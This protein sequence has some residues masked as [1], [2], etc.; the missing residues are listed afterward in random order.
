MSGTFS[1]SSF[2]K[3]LVA[4]F[5][6]SCTTS[7]PAQSK[8]TYWQQEVRYTM[9]I[10]MDVS[11]N[12]YSG[13]QKIRYKNNS[14]DIL[15]KAFFHLYLNAFQPNSVMD[16]R[17][18]TIPDPDGRIGERILYLSPDEIGY[19]KINK[20]TMNGTPL[21]YEVNGTILE[22]QLAK[23]IRPGQTVT[24]DMEYDAQ[25]PVQI[26]R[27]G[28]DNKEGIRYS[29]SQWY[30]KL[31]EYDRDGWHANPYIGREFYGVWGNFE[32]NLTID[33]DYVVAATG[34]LQNAKEIGHGYA[35]EPKAKKDYL[36][37]K[38]KAERVHDFVWA[39]DPD[40]VHDVHTTRDGITLHAFYQDTHDFVEN[41]KDLLPI[42]DE[43]F[44]FSNQL[45]G[46]YPYPVYSF[47]QGGDGGM[48]YPMATLITGHRS[49]TSLVGVSV[50]ELM[51]SWFQM[52]YGFNESLYYWMDEGFTSY[53]ETRVIDHL[54]K[55]RLIPGEPA[56]NPYEQALKGYKNLVDRGFEEPLS[57]HADHFN[58]NT[59][60]SI[61][62]YTKGEVFLYQLNYV[63]GKEAVERGLIDFFEQWKY[64]HP[65]D[66]DFV[67]VMEKASD[68]ELDWYREYM[69][70]SVKTIDYAIDT[71]MS[72]AS[73]T[74]IELRRI[75]FM[76]M[77]VD[78]AVKLTSG[79]TNFYTI[80]LDLM[81]GSK[82]E[83]G[84][85][86][87]PDWNWVNPTY[88]LEIPF[89]LSQIE[90]IIIDPG[91]GSADMNRD[92]DEWPKPQSPTE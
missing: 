62:A 61:S 73:V 4:L 28:R 48:E 3:I 45:L 92:N 34:V 36:T 2:H 89:P 69:V 57:T 33:A 32:F 6:V 81:R 53:A 52:L 26:R 27:T 18:R 86:I 10:T 51:H 84:H 22:V 11:T 35:P 66:R 24:F 87:Q 9:D 17:S 15:T 8:K 63:I 49:L 88:F 16:V 37:W 1:V 55:K 78:V 75:G 68:I 41:W 20:L 21:K 83:A 39:A 50:H 60:Y 44:S 90:S 70:N 25:V 54:K 59:S 12:R 65:T 40:F 72:N 76:P 56:A 91:H 5:L 14:P 71:V 80:P 23:P 38:F 13:H 82:K 31:C 79:Q 29:M 30:P 46:K 47:I 19:Q 42:M 85:I 58:Y 67:R 64:K 74:G 77:P 43:A 7:L